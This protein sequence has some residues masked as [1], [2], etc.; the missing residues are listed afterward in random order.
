LCLMFLLTIGGQR[1]AAAK[2]EKDELKRNKTDDAT[3]NNAGN[4][5]PRK[6]V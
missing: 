3:D 5:T 6:A 1:L 2:P 4:R